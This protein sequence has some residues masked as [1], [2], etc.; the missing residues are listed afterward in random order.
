M[1]PA[2]MEREMTRY[3]TNSHGVKFYIEK[4]KD[5]DD[6]GRSIEGKG[7]FA[8]LVVGRDEIGGVWFETECAALTAVAEH[9]G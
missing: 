7:W 9:R 8:G 1:T 2:M 6:D 3:I 4:A 5:F